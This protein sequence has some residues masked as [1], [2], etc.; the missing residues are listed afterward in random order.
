MR[1]LR[2]HECISTHMTAFLHMY[3]KAH[4]NYTY[5]AALHLTKLVFYTILHYTYTTPTIFVSWVYV[6]P[7]FIGL[8]AAI[9]VSPLL[10]SC[11]LFRACVCSWYVCLC[12]HRQ[13]NWCICAYTLTCVHTHMCSHSHGNLPQIYKSTHWCAH[14][15]M[16]CMH[17]FTQ[18]SLAQRQA[19]KLIRIWGGWGLYMGVSWV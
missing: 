9:V 2:S 13:V 4:T 11:A 19:T 18:R 10:Q 14:T 1:T 12:S 5:T 7:A 16:I 15:H 17:T 8:E 3:K 6:I